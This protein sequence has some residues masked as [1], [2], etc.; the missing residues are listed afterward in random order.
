VKPEIINIPQEFVADFWV[1]QKKK[2]KIKC[3]QENVGVGART[4]GRNVLDSFFLFR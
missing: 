1:S 4:Y 3:R 2:I